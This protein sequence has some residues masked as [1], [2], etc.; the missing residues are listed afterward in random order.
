MLGVPVSLVAGFSGGARI[1]GL[2]CFTYIAGARDFYLVPCTGDSAP[3]PGA[4]S[5]A[6]I[7]SDVAVSAPGGSAS[8]DLSPEGA[9]AEGPIAAEIKAGGG[10]IRS[11]PN[12]LGLFPRVNIALEEKVEVSVVYAEAQPGDMVVVQ[13]EDGGVLDQNRTALQLKLDGERRLRF[14][15]KSTA[16]GGIYRVTLRRGFEEKRLEFWGGKAPVANSSLTDRLAVEGENF[17]LTQKGGESCRFRKVM[18][19]GLSVIVNGRA[20]TV[21]TAAYVME[22]M[23]DVSGNVYRLEYNSSRQLTKVSEPAGR[24]FSINY[25]TLSGNKLNPA[26]LATLGKAPAAGAWTE[27]TV[28]NGTAFRYVRMVQ[29]D[30]SFGQIAEVEFYEAGTGAKLTGQIICSDSADLGQLATDGQPETGFVSAAQSGGFVG[31]DLGTAKRIGRVRFLSVAGKESLHKPGGFGAAALRIEGANQAP[32]ST[33]AIASVQTGDGRSV[34]YNYTNLND[35]TLP[36]AFPCLTAAR[37]S[38]GSQATYKYVQ[39]F[40]GTRPL[41]GEWDDV[42][43]ELRQGRYKTVYQNSITGAVLGAV[44]SQVNLETG[45][46]ILTIGLYNNSLHAPMVT[47]GNGGADVQIYSMLSTGAA[48]TQEI[49]ANKNSTFY[50]YDPNGYMATRKDPLGRITCYTWTPQGNPLSQTNPDGSIERWSYNERNLLIGHTDTLGR[51]TSYTRDGRNRITRTDYPDGA[52]LRHGS[53]M[54]SAR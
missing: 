40:P 39:V 16:E 48:I 44:A 4:K 14:A 30:K 7:A 46:P 54:R 32:V 9:S 12:A 17:V 41:V 28:S 31:L 38:D 36:Y 42:R 45:R 26:T 47:Y 10:V 15:F 24:S 6:P 3:A 35:P 33:I 23:R 5:V 50:T 37:Y 11:A 49:D 29:A 53:T 25:A 20:V 2:R 22:E 13:A 52:P 21:L 51:T 34:T 19:P 8:D 1:R 27:F 18:V 43:Y